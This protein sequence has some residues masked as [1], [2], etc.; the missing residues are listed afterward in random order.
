V[1]PEIGTEKAA[2]VLRTGGRFA[3]FWNHAV[4][5]PEIMEI[6]EPI[7]RRHAPHLLEDG[8]VVLGPTTRDPVVDRYAAEAL[9]AS[10]AFTDIE[11]RTYR[12][13]RSYTV[14]SWLDQ[15]PTH[16]DHRSLE[17]QVRTALFEELADGLRRV[18]EPFE[19]GYRTAM[20]TAVRSE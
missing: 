2:S 5:E 20:A 9:Q 13:T 6:F 10:D 18:G 15:L 12:W 17:P 14:A 3:A 19:I 4:H 8:S 16:N 11:R 7:Y 1:D